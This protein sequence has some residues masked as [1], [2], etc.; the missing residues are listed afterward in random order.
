[1][2]DSGTAAHNA[3]KQAKQVSE[4]EVPLNNR[5]HFDPP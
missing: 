3:V 5:S 4:R 2:K 1:M